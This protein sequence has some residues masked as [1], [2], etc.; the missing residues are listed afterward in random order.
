MLTQTAVRSGKLRTG[1]N[2]YSGGIR[3]SVT[4]FAT[5]W[6]AATSKYP[7]HAALKNLTARDC[8]RLSPGSADAAQLDFDKQLEKAIV[9]AAG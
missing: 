2:R 8:S 5:A 4:V 9:A 6:L 3:N 7:A 1:K